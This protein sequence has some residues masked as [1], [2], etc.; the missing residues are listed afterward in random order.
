V[1]PFG[2]RDPALPF[3]V[4]EDILRAGHFMFNPAVPT[5]SFRVATGDLRRVYAAVPNPVSTFG[6]DED[7]RFV[8]R[9]MEKGA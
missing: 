5:K 8:I 2:H 9:R 1:P 3:Y 4:D 7:E 6:E